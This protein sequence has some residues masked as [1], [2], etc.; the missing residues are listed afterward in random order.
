MRRF[1]LTSGSRCRAGSKPLAHTHIA[2]RRDPDYA[3]AHRLLA[4][5]YAELAQ[6][7]PS[8]LEQAERH[9]RAAA[10]APESDSPTATGFVPE[11]S[12][13]SQ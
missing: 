10:V 3:P 11:G 9:R 5:Y 1:Q 7:D 4:G 13:P 12:I 8:Y 2:D 6:K